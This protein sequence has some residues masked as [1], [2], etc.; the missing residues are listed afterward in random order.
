VLRE[1]GL[2][3]PV[4][5]GPGQRPGVRATACGPLSAGGG[6]LR[7][8]A[9]EG[10]IWGAGGA[11]D[12]EAL[13]V[14]AGQGP[15]DLLRLDCYC[16]RIYGSTCAPSRIRTCA[17][18]SGDHARLRDGTGVTC[19]NTPTTRT[20]T[21]SLSRFSRGGERGCAPDAMPQVVVSLRSP[22]DGRLVIDLLQPSA[23]TSRWDCWEIAHRRCT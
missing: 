23:D 4:V 1:D 16:V 11:Q 20:W 12:R 17:H 2:V 15:A 18:G 14:G 3:R 19:G 21:D 8:W 22:L 7:V 10:V 13:S 9:P 6:G 5:L